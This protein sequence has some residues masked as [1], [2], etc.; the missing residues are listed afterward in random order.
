MLL[1][2][3]FTARNRN[4]M[5]RDSGADMAPISTPI[6]PSLSASQSGSQSAAP[7]DIW[8]HAKQLFP[9]GGAAPVSD[10]LLQISGDRIALIRP[11]SQIASAPE[12]HFYDVVAPGFI[13]LQINGGGG[14]LFNDSPDLPAVNAIAAAA[15]QGGACHILPTFITAP[16][17]EYGR[18]MEAVS[19]AADRPEILGLHLEGPFLSPARAGIH[20]ADFMRQ[21][22]ARD[23][24][25]L[26]GF[27]GRLLL[28]CAPEQV[29][30]ADIRALI[31][32]GVI[33]FAGHSD[34]DIEMMNAAISA[35]LSGV[36]HLFN[37]CSQLNAREPGIVGAA[38]SDSRLFAGIIADRYHVHDANLKLAVAQMHDRLCLVSDTMPS[39][40]TN[41]LGFV[42]QGREITLKDGR[43]VSA[44]G[45]LAGAHLGLDE[46]VRNIIS[47]TQIAPE[48]A[49]HMAS[50]IPAKIVG[51]DSEYGAV[52]EGRLASL[53]CL[54][55]GLRACAVYVHGTGYF[56]DI[57]D[58]VL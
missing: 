37:A 42:L 24:A 2:I 49:L 7:S 22:D 8:I 15:R 45:Q 54:D 19:R 3:C 18:A 23:V 44:E 46:A 40:G 5:K 53:T 16:E 28:T 57:A 32:A 10:Q 26:T 50:G 43:L 13:D 30:L 11:A 48:K 12:A 14:I 27:E 47:A 31:D 34:A 20:N 6:S 51:L 52:R 38:L 58:A 56:P 29:T 4:A 17:Q 1:T 35:G 9:G 39:F 41:L 36:T 25:R 55:R 33:V 21:M